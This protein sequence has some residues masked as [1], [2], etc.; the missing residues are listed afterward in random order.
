MV[1]R[2][3]AVEQMS[4]G[5]KVFIMDNQPKHSR[6]FIAFAGEMKDVELVVV[7]LGYS[8]RKSTCGLFWTGATQAEELSFG[9]A[10]RRTAVVVNDMKNPL[11]VLEA[12]LS[13][14]HAPSG[15]PDIRG[16]FENGRG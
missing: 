4:D 16:E 5:A 1:D 2:K 15:N 11:L 8:A 9:D 7:D 6:P 12:V 10:V 14:Y 3:G 13:T